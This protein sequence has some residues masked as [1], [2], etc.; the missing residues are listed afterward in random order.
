MLMKALHAYRSSQ[1]AGG[2]SVH[3]D[4][5]ERSLTNGDS[6]EKSLAHLDEPER[7]FAHEDSPGREE[8]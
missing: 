2:F 5:P 6:L 4:Q 1:R 3:G 7:N 8:M